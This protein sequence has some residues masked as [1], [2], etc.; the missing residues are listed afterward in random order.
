[1]PVSQYLAFYGLGFTGRSGQYH[2]R[3]TLDDEDVFVLNRGV[4]VLLS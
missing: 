3:D 2:L 4:F 1:M